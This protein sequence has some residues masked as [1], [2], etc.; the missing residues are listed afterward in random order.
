MITKHPFPNKLINDFIRYAKTIFPNEACGFFIDD[1]FIPQ[2]N[3]HPD[4]QNN[5]EIDSKQFILNEDKIQ[6]IIHSHNNYPH[7]SKNDM[8]QQIATDVPWGMVN[9]INNQP[10]EIVFWGNDIDNYPL[11]GRP[12]VH[13]VWDCYGLVRSYYKNVKGIIIKDFPREMNWWKK[14]PSMLENN[15]ESAHFKRIDKSKVQ[16]GD[17]VF[18]K[19]GKV[20]CHAAIFLK[21]YTVLHHLVSKLSNVEP[22]NRWKDR[23]QGFY[24]YIGDK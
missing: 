16:E 15:F 21:N 20:T 22:I 23:I 18:M 19:I 3:R 13:G 4:K 24:R 14:E 17:V 8:L 6:C 12:F 10:N 7:L 11:K 9:L 2:E 1:E 5:F